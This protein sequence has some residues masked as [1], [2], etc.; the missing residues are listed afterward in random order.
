MALTKKEYNRMEKDY[1]RADY[2]YAKMKKGAKSMKSMSPAANPNYDYKSC[3]VGGM[4][5]VMKDKK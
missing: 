3:I 1:K 2:D 4:H 5:P